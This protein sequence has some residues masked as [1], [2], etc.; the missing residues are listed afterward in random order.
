MMKSPNSWSC[1]PMAMSYLLDIP[2]ENLLHDFG[3]DGSEILDARLPAPYNRRAFTVEEATFVAFKNGF[4][5]PAIWRF[6]RHGNLEFKI[7]GWNPDTMLT[8]FDGLLG[9]LSAGGI[10]HV[11]AWKNGRVLDPAC[12]GEFSYPNPFSEIYCFI[13]F[14]KSNHWWKENKIST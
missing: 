5:A 8:E 13:P 9:G 4:F 14:L 2:F 1:I 6:T 7:P 3:H 11:C 12:A 10:P